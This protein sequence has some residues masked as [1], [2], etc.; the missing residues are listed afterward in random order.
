MKKDSEKIKNKNLKNK[1]FILLSGFLLIIAIII[2]FI[3]RKDDKNID[4]II[5]SN[6][7]TTIGITSTSST[8][9]D[10]L[11]KA[12]SLTI[13]KN[14]ILENS[15]NSNCLNFTSD[16]KYNDSDKDLNKGIAQLQRFLQQNGYYYYSYS[17]N[18]VFDENTGY[19]LS[20]FFDDNNLSSLYSSNDYDFYQDNNL[21][22]TSLQKI[23]SSKSFACPLKNDLNKSDIR[24]LDSISGLNNGSSEDSEYAPIKEVKK[25]DDG[26]VFVKS[27]KYDNSA[28]CSAY[29]K[30]YYNSEKDINLEVG[31][32]GLYKYKLTYSENNLGDYGEKQ[33][34]LLFKLIDGKY[35]SHVYTPISC[36]SIDKVF[37]NQD[38]KT[39]SYVCKVTNKTTGKIEMA[40][41]TDIY[42]GEE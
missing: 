11:Y 28:K 39:L 14:K 4:N 21:A 12:N 25:Y 6:A 36:Q 30:Y 3:F 10:N 37:Y 23:F 38:S 26:T 8:P 1:I 7:G 27:C 40:T 19:A 24:F 20:S 34:Y 5:V 15:Q 2:F 35:Y 9:F 42:L 29:I 33:E 16:I 32:D 22:S 17:I 13:L 41:G 31:L 18:G